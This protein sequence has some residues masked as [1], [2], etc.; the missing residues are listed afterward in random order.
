MGSLY[1]SPYFLRPILVRAS[2]CFSPGSC[3]PVNFGPGNGLASDEVGAA[4][5][6]ATK[7]RVALAGNAA[8]RSAATS[9]FSRVAGEKISM[10][11]AR[12]GDDLYM[13]GFGKKSTGIW[14]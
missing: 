1:P 9:P 11:I 6:P 12:R 5:A 2:S 3:S 7:Q 4:G 10:R 8:E 14:L 13:G